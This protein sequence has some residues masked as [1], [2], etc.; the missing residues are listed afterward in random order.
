VL[1]A[2]SGVVVPM[3]RTELVAVA[4]SVVVVADS[5]SVA[6]VEADGVTSDWVDVD[7]L[8]TAED[9]AVSSLVERPV[10][11]VDATVVVAS[12]AAV[13][14]LDATVW[15]AMTVATLRMGTTAIP[16]N[17][18]YP[19]PAVLWVGARIPIQSSIPLLFDISSLLINRAQCLCNRSIEN[20]LVALARCVRNGPRCKRRLRVIFNFRLPHHICI[21]IALHKKH[22]A[23]NKHRPRL[24]ECRI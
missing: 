8:A 1:V 19:I 6:V 12:L 3:A 15:A 20:N 16:I 23:P 14:V 11:V 5:N 24:T 17:A 4:R 13:S 18:Q 2:V 10:D 7:A 22:S 9:V 21:T